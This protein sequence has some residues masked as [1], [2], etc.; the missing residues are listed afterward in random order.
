[1][2]VRLE[3][4]KTKNY[5]LVVEDDNIGSIDDVS[6]KEVRTPRLLPSEL[7]DIVQIIHTPGDFR[8]T[9]I[10]ISDSSVL[11]VHGLAIN[12]RTYLSYSSK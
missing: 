5:V 1:M 3:Y 7:L 11:N 10:S 4:F 6:R 12:Q 8:L 9:D 2:I